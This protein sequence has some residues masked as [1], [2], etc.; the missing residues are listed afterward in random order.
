MLKLNSIYRWPMGDDEQ[1][2]QD[3]KPS[4][5]FTVVDVLPDGLVKI[6]WCNGEVDTMS[7]D[8]DQDLYIPEVLAV[9]DYEELKG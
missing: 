8:S 1:S 9:G 6:K 3:T 7:T 5:W 4:L 2:M